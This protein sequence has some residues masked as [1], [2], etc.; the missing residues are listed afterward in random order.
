MAT[1][2]PTNPLPFHRRLRRVLVVAALL[3][4]ILL[5]WAWQNLRRDSVTAS[6]YAARVACSCRFVAGR[7]L[8]DCKAELAAGLTPVML[9]E[10]AEVKSVTARSLLS[11]QTATFREGPGCQ[12]ERWQD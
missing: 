10:N 4:V 5:G 8:S 9:S 1:A 7:P 12:L 3:G 11:V 2:K 6:S